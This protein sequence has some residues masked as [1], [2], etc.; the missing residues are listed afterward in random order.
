[1]DQS[2]EVLIYLRLTVWNTIHKSLN[3]A[4]YMYKSRPSFDLA[5]YVHPHVSVFIMDQLS[6]AGPKLGKA[7]WRRGRRGEGGNAGTWEPL[8]NPPSARHGTFAEQ[9]PPTLKA[10]NRRQTQQRDRPCSGRTVFGDESAGIRGGGA[11]DGANKEAEKHCGSAK[12]CVEEQTLTDRETASFHW[13]G[14]GESC[15]PGTAV[16]CSRVR[17]APSVL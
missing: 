8:A 12:L 6:C 4:Q 14:S 16:R 17:V 15:S 3:S 7:C 5:E 11:A 9:G 10:C 13:C 2:N 1:M